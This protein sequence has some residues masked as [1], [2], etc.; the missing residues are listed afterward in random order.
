MQKTLELRALQAE[1]DFVQEYG[2]LDQRS[3]TILEYNVAYVKLQEYGVSK[4]IHEDF[5]TS[6]GRIV[7]AGGYDYKDIA[8]IKSEMYQ[9][10]GIDCPDGYNCPRRFLAWESKY[11]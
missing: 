5:M 3:R 9:E 2:T 7:E 6:Y 10:I 4:A 11:S 8:A 1:L